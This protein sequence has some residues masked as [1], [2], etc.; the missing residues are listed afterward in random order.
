MPVNSIIVTIITSVMV[1][2]STGSKI[3]VPKWKGM[4]GANQAASATF[5]KCIIPSAAAMTPPTTM[6]TSTAML[7][8]KPL[9]KRATPMTTA[10]TTSDRMMFVT[11]A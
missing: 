6:P 1:T 11:G 4:I 2:I 10:S 8:R 9:A 5:S 3:G 7:D